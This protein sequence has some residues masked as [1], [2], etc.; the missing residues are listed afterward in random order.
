MVAPRV[1]AR[2]GAAGR[3]GVSPVKRPSL[4]GRQAFHT[5]KVGETD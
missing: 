4:G 3:L 5:E 1:Q 2:G